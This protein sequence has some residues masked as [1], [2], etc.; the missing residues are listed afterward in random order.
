MKKLACL[1]LIVAASGCP[2]I[3]TDPFDEETPQEPVVEFDPSNKII[4]FPNNLLLDATTGKVSLPAQCNESVAG[5]V[6]RESALNKL[7]GFGMFETALTVTFSEDVDAASLAERIVLYKRQTGTAQVDPAAAVPIPVVTQ[8]ATT[9]RY[10]LS[11]GNP[12]MIPQLIIIP[13]VPLEQKSSYVVALLD[14]IKTA[15]GAAFTASGT[16]R[17][18]RGAKNPVTIKE[19]IVVANETPLDPTKREDRE[20]LDGI[21]L[22]WRAH[23]AALKFVA[24]DLPA[25]KQQSRDKILL[26]WEFKTQTSTDP[27]DPMVAGSPASE[28]D[29][30]MGLVQN[31]SLPGFSRVTPPFDQCKPTDSDTQCYLKIRIGNNSY[32]TGDALCLQLGCAAIG[33]VVGSGLISKQYQVDTP[34]QYTGTGAKPIPGPWADPNT[35]ASVKSEAIEV[36]SLI[37]AA[38]P[39]PT[40]YPVVIFQHGLGQSKTN[41]FAI[42]GQLA[43]L[44]F[45]TVAIDAVSH[46]SRA[47]RISN[48]SARLCADPSP[49]PC[50]RADCGPSPIDHPQCYA[51]FLS[52]NLPATRDGIRQTVIDQQRL[53][54]ALKACGTANCGPVK[55]DPAHILYVGQSLGGIIGSISTA[56]TPDIKAAVLNVPGVGWADILENTQTLA[57]QC[58]LVDGLIAVG[59]LQGEPSNLTAVP[60]TGLCTTPAWKAQ[61]GYRQFS[62]IGRWLLDAADPA[63]FTRKLA[64]RRFLIQEVVGDT[65]VPNIATT[66]EGMLV[67]LMP[68]T[69]DSINP[70][71]PPPAPPPAA[72]GSITTNPTTSKWVR[73]PTLPANGAFLGNTFGHGSLLQPPPQSGTAGQLGTL[74]MQVDAL[75]YLFANQ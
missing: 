73:Y 8:L 20:R 74:R 25:D 75:T 2:N 35:P 26:A 42:A 29:R 69:A 61:P 60:P 66:N 22:L 17:L 6:I 62:V 64:T 51:P 31:T 36:L 27:L 43:A 54:A 32:A 10:D 19:G 44:G 30:A 57:I 41:A 72:S 45:A 63:N 55:V 59:I 16:W 7:D 70:P 28:I 9:T 50:A 33:D 49:P 11:C 38:A 24:D 47:V 3:K 13:R 12:A 52:P 1:F 67:G 68:G 56:M 46:D 4:P 40:G 71:Q 21:D 65:V 5:R 18:V 23:A 48:D 37:P 58:M 34:N 14:G 39:P 15:K 53:V